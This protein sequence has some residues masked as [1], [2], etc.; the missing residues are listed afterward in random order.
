MYVNNTFLAFIERAKSIGS[1][2]KNIMMSDC[3]HNSYTIPLL[4]RYCEWSKEGGQSE[5]AAVTFI[6]KFTEIDTGAVIVRDSSTK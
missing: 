6:V 2:P 1:S 5:R 3:A 4:T